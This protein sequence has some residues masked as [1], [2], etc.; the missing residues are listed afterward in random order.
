MIFRE[1]DSVDHTHLKSLT[2]IKAEKHQLPVAGVIN[3]AFND[4]WVLKF[5]RFTKFEKT[6]EKLGKSFSPEFYF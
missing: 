6:K 2:A 4:R 1:A 5:S 3:S